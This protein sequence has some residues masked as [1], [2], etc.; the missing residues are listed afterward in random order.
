MI[1]GHIS[2][3]A[4]I[5]AASVLTL[6]QA[7]A[8]LFD[9]GSTFTASGLNSAGSF[10]N[11][12]TLQNG[13]TAIDG[14][15][16]DLTISIVPDGSSE[17]LVFTYQSST[18]DTPLM[19]NTSDDWNVYETGLDA[20]VATDFD[21]AYAAFLDSSGNAITPTSSIF[22]GY[23]VIPNPVPGGAGI[24]L[25]TGSFTDDNPAGPYFALG[26]YIEPFDYL[27]SGAGIP[28][29]NVDGFVQALEFSPTSAVPEP[30]SLS[31]V[32][33]GLVGLA[34]LAFRRRHNRA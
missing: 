13:T 6:G 32:C 30:A 16:I 8:D 20:A 22:P 28:S 4:V 21:R 17:W 2:T 26:A 14:G 29:A 12:V 34:G 23:S 19:S 5:V 18:P 25:G 11:T 10:S 15:A 9:I 24:G 7:K 27:D 33:T 1:L 31:L 3:G